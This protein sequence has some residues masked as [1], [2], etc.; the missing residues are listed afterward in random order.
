MVET[1]VNQSWKKRRVWPVFFG[2]CF[3]LIVDLCGL[4]ASRRKGGA[5]R[6]R[7]EELIINHSGTGFS[8][9]AGGFGHW[10]TLD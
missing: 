4:K 5:E 10:V 7:G 6:D 2:Q 9:E 3:I 8:R 1:L